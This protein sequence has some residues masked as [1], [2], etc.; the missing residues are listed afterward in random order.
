MQ[1]LLQNI[2]ISE[3]LKQLRRECKIS[4]YDIVKLLEKMGRSMS[5]VS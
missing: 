4:Q 3:N 2:H 5:R 1:K